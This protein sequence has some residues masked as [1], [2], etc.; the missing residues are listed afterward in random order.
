MERMD[1]AVR[2]AIE[3]RPEGSEET[4]LPR[5]W[6]I[7]CPVEGVCLGTWAP[8]EASVTGTE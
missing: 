8:T 2:E 1:L 5:E 4:S 6:Q 7:K 3:K